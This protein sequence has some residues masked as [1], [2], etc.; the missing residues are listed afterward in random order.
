MVAVELDSSLMDGRSAAAGTKG[1]SN[2]VNF[3]LEM[4]RNSL[5]VI[6][7]SSCWALEYNVGLVGER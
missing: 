6:F 3:G 5:S 4:P 7:S 1:K 2:D